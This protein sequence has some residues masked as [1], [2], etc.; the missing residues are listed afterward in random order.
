MFG[1]I[2]NAALRLG[3]AWDELNSKIEELDMDGSKNLA[4]WRRF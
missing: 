4:S 1:L 3:D 2:N